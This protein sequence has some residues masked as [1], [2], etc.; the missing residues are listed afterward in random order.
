MNKIKSL[1]FLCVCVSVI[2]ACGETTNALFFA[3]KFNIQSVAVGISRY[4]SNVE[5]WFC[6]TSLTN[7]TRHL[8]A[9]NEKS[10]D[11]YCAVKH[12][13]T[14]KIMPDDVRNAHKIDR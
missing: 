7:R 2:F 10:N 4:K 5:C 1:L 3:A 14:P 6:F 11:L 8:K 13:V 12:R 9:R